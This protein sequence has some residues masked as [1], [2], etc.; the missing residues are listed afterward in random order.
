MKKVR[1][2]QILEQN[3]LGLY[4]HTK[5]RK[6]SGEVGKNPFQVTNGSQSHDKGDPLAPRKKHRKKKWIFGLKLFLR[7]HRFKQMVKAHQDG[8]KG[9]N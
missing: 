9:T 2:K 3:V 4:Q 8:R 1:K 5:R 7:R 6:M